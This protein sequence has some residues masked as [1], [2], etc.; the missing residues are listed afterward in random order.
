MRRVFVNRVA[1][2]F[3]PQAVHASFMS[4]ATDILDDPRMKTVLHRV[5]SRSGIEHR[6]SYLQMKKPL[7][8]GS[9]DAS[10]FFRPGPFPSTGARMQLFEKLAPRLAFQ[11]LDALR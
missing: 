2:S 3:P 11:A 6:Y 1:S 7:H 5:A 4:C 10:K 8:K 9:I